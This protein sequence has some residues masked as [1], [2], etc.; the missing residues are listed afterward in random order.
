[1][2]VFSFLFDATSFPLESKYP[3]HLD[4]ATPLQE[5]GRR[6]ESGE[7]SNRPKL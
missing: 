3:L 4:S 2:D 7:A 5:Y 1:M 6:K